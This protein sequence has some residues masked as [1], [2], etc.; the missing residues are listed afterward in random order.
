MKKYALLGASALAAI[1][2]IGQA[3]QA[4]SLQD[5]LGPNVTDLLGKYEDGSFSNLAVNTGAIDASINASADQSALGG[6][7]NL[8]IKGSEAAQDA[9]NA[10]EESASSSA[11]SSSSNGAGATSAN[12]EQA[13]SEAASNAQSSASSSSFEASLDI[14]VEPMDVRQSLGDVST[15]AIGALNSGDINL[16]PETAELGLE[17]SVTVSASSAEATDTAAEAE[18][19]YGNLDLDVDYAYQG[20]PDVTAMNLAY[21]IADINGSVT[22][23]GLGADSIA[24]TAIGAANFGSITVGSPAPASE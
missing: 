3:A 23:D 4:Q 9:S 21:N 24:T 11:S 15:T 19:F 8:T 17:G 18:A 22:L 12:A 2:M 20:V 7:L 16:V 5:V 13:A 6:S 10:A 1:T 14:S